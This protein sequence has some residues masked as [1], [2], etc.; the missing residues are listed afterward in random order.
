M[1]RRTAAL[2]LL[3][4]LIPF[5]HAQEEAGSLLDAG[6]A[7]VAAFE[8]Q[9]SEI[10]QL[11]QEGSQI[12]AAVERARASGDTA[13]IEALRQSWMALETKIQ[14][15]QG[16]LERLKTEATEAYEKAL[17]LDPSASR[18]YT[19]RAQLRLATGDLDGGAT[20]LERAVAL[21]PDDMS[22]PR[23]DPPP[24]PRSS[25]PRNA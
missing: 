22:G 15:V 7:A 11:Q 8:R 6:D 25:R 13:A 17:E 1:I 5:A 14:T 24:R 20:D 18:A 23:I 3:S 21:G 10:P 4:S 19:G 16:A 9:A 2:L 12:R